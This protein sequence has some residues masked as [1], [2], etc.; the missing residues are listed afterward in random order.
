MWTQLWAYL[1]EQGNY[2]SDYHRGVWLLPPASACS[3]SG[4][5]GVFS[6]L[7]FSAMRC[8]CG[9]RCA[10]RYYCC[11]STQC[12]TH[13]ACGSAV[14][15]LSRLLHVLSQWRFTPSVLSQ[16]SPVEDTPCP[17]DTWCW[18]LDL[19]WWRTRF[20]LLRLESCFASFHHHRIVFSSP[21]HWMAVFQ[22]LRTTFNLRLSLLPSALFFAKGRILIQLQPH[23]FFFFD[24][25]PCLTITWEKLKYSAMPKNSSTT[26]I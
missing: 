22:N 20:L 16:A 21:C 25:Q 4:L 18:S 7:P 2:T 9:Q 6:V 23:L 10:G 17:L 12:K 24:S 3:S 8:W 14:S 11:P 26:H 19:F 5:G 13:R 15:E 1:L